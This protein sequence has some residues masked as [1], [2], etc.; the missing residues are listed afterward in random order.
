[1]LNSRCIR[2]SKQRRNED[3]R[4]QLP[5]KN[6]EGQAVG[7]PLGPDYGVRS[8]QSARLPCRGQQDMK[9]Q[10]RSRTAYHMQVNLPTSAKSRHSITIIG[11][12]LSST[13]VVMTREV[14]IPWIDN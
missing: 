12:K 13:T 3:E 1:M 4:R 11:P 8:M 2:I 14:L 9:L 10:R 7:A 6:T 5:L